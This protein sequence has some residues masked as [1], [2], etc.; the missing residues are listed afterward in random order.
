MQLNGR[1]Q[2]SEH[3][4]V[5]V[6]ISKPLCPNTANNSTI[7]ISSHTATESANVNFGKDNTQHNTTQRNATRK[8][9]KQPHSD[10]LM[11]LCRNQ[12]PVGPRHTAASTASRSR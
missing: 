1:Q 12:L 2:G 5:S 7:G 9:Y 6:H 3:A 4:F 11:N 8:A 10:P